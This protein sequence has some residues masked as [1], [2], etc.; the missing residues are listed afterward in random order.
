MAWGGHE[1]WAADRGCHA[2]TCSWK[3]IPRKRGCIHGRSS[4]N[5][6]PAQVTKPAP[7]RIGGTQAHKLLLRGF[8]STDRKSCHLHRRPTSVRA[9]AVIAGH[10]MSP[11]ETHQARTAS[12]SLQIYHRSSIHHERSSAGT[13]GAGV[14]ADTGWRVEV[15]ESM[16]DR[17]APAVV[18]PRL[19]RL[20]F[21]MPSTVHI[22]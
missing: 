9:H 18:Q 20:G 11:P 12:A 10:V 4:P 6:P 16:A 14:G 22:L 8:D 21:F 1:N 7:R 13:A 15:T 3:E 17:A 2:A 5:P 19:V